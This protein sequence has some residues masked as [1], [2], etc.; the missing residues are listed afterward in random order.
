MIII[1]FFILL[2]V[3]IDIRCI[4][5]LKIE[6]YKGNF[7]FH[8][9]NK[10]KGRIISHLFVE[11]KY[12]KKLPFSDRFIIERL[13][14]NYKFISLNKGSK[15]IKD[16]LRFSI[17]NE[18]NNT[19]NKSQKERNTYKNK[20]SNNTNNR[21]NIEVNEKKKV[22]N[23]NYKNK[24]VKNE[25]YKNKKVE[26]ENY[27]NKNVENEN[28]KN[29]KVENENYKNKNVENE[30]YKN[31]NVENENYKNKNVENENYKNKNVENENYKNK[32]VKN[33]NYK[34]KNVENENY[35][36]KNVENENYKN[37]NVENENYK[38]KNVEK[39][40]S[41]KEAKSTKKE[42]EEIA[43]KKITKKI[44]KGTINNNYGYYN[45]VRS[46][47]N[48]VDIQNTTVRDF[49]IEHNE[50]RSLKLL[51]LIYKFW[52]NKNFLNFFD[53]L[54]N[55]NF[56]YTCIEKWLHK[57]S[58]SLSKKQLKIKIM[59]DHI[60]IKNE[61]FLKKKK[62]IKEFKISYCSINKCLN[63]LINNFDKFCSYEITSIVWAIT[64]I[65]IKSFK[66]SNN[67]DFGNSLEFN[68][69]NL[70][71]I[72]NFNTFFSLIIKNLNKIKNYLSVDEALWAIWSI[73]KLLYFNI[74]I[75]NYLTS[76]K[77][78][79]D[80]NLQNDNNNDNNS[81]LILD[82]SRGYI[83]NIE[84]NEN[85]NNLKK[86][87]DI[88]ILNSCTTENNKNLNGKKLNEIHD[89]KNFIKYNNNKIV[90]MMKKFKLTREIVINILDVFDYLYSKLYNNITFLKE[91][92]YIYIPFIIFESQTLILNNGIILLNRIIYLI[93]NNNILLKLFNFNS[94]K[95]TYSKNSNL[96]QNDL[97]KNKD[98]F[99][100]KTL[101]KVYKLIKCISK[102]FYPLKN[103]NLLNFDLHNNY[104][105]LNINILSKFINTCN[106]VL[107]KYIDYFIFIM[108][109]KN[110]TKEKESIKIQ[111]EKNQDNENNK[112]DN[113]GKE[114]NTEMNNNIKENII[115]LNDKVKL[116]YKNEIV[117]IYN[118]LK[119]SL[120]S[121]IK[122]DLKDKFIYEWLNK[123][124]HI[125]QFNRLDETNKLYELKNKLIENNEYPILNNKEENN[126]IN[127][128]MDKIKDNSIKIDENES[129]LMNEKKEIEEDIFSETNSIHLP[130]D[131]KSE[132]NKV[133]DEKNEKLSVL[134]N[135]DMKTYLN[136]IKNNSDINKNNSDV[137]LDVLA[138]SK[139]T[140][141]YNNEMKTKL[142]EN[143]TYS[144]EHSLKIFKI[145]YENEKISNPS[146]VTINDIYI[147]KDKNIEELYNEETKTFYKKNKSIEFRNII[148]PKQLSIFVNYI[149]RNIHLIPKQEL[150]NIFLISIKYAI[151]TKFNY[152]TSNDIIHFLQGLINYNE[153][154]NHSKFYYDVI[155]EMLMLLCDIVE[156]NFLNWKSSNI[157]Q[158]IYVLTKFKHIHK[159]IFNK[160]D[161]FLN[162]IKFPY[163]IYQKANYIN[164][165]NVLQ[166][167]HDSNLTE[168]KKNNNINISQISNNNS[169][170][171]NGN[172]NNIIE[173][174][175]KFHKNNENQR[176]DISINEFKYDNL[177]SAIWALSSLNKNVIK[178]KY[179]LK[180]FYFFSV[181]FSLH[182]K[183]Y[184][185]YKIR[186]NNYA[187][188]N[189]ENLKKKYLNDSKFLQYNTNYFKIPLDPMTISIYVNIFARK[190]KKGF[191][192]LFE[193]IYNN[194]DIINLF[195]LKELS[196]VIYSLSHINKNSLQD[197]VF[198][199]SIL[200]NINSLE[201]KESYF[202]EEF[203]KSNI[204]LWIEELDYLFCFDHSK[205]LHEIK[206]KNTDQS[207]NIK[208]EDMGNKNGENI[209]DN[210]YQTENDYKN[211][212]E[213]IINTNSYDEK[214]KNFIR[215]DKFLK[216]K[217]ERI[218]LSNEFLNMLMERLIYFTIYILEEKKNTQEISSNN[219]TFTRNFNKK[220]KIEIIDLI[221]L[222]YSF[223]ILL[224]QKVQINETKN[225]NFHR[226][227]KLISQYNLIV[228]NFLHSF[229][230]IYFV[231]DTYALVSNIYYLDQSTRNIIKEFVKICI[232][233]IEEEKI[234]DLEKKKITLSIQ[235][236]K[237]TNF[238]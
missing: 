112:I 145:I 158:L 232:K 221:K 5:S 38:N 121:L 180:F 36:N 212:S 10:N 183:L 25:N 68:N 224:N 52:K 98:I 190:I 115:E 186:N 210:I 27:K 18:S 193:V 73:C 56:D 188:Y 151:T 123:N 187:L 23:E 134:N 60:L 129:A 2:F 13:K 128:E 133:N 230:Y 125:F 114:N 34:N 171:M 209:N 195:S 234:L 202:L 70:T 126:S 130:Y 72:E 231:I 185:H 215:K 14:N 150:D 132:Y 177:G 91:K 41:Y 207:M 220:N 85:I 163:Y 162:N 35:K 175:N 196:H 9:Y 43:K 119:S 116:E 198:D 89:N 57:L 49:L 47:Y 118:C 181:Y 11:V 124:V 176:I 93:L 137:C 203:L 178:K 88:K 136:L 144:I 166:G 201:E 153:L 169:E 78:F 87:G 109:F 173:K 138:L 32:N 19:I 95:N 238:K 4:I 146:Y 223:F 217:H 76:S 122:L 206:N 237:V 219:R 139:F 157:C 24:N 74:S 225:I 117:F 39:K 222:I 194:V 46:T 3:L 143:V 97:D 28:Y 31:K 90:Y 192:F 160:F 235:N 191:Y 29:K 84:D 218:N 135:T 83:E 184:L 67:L 75:N 167:N 12:R 107:V 94:L 214:Y 172:F 15:N 228:K 42:N 147:I 79:I 131:S 40:V 164:H 33:E 226:L 127:L 59:N 16:K 20:T 152:F 211:D 216:L 61:H 101:S 233:K 80:K 100:I 179:Y 205:N 110:D 65:I 149:G 50:I 174:N 104:K 22:E 21:D 48:I 69:V 106:D 159:F 37:K 102:T 62:R 58:I 189:K 120:V 51:D 53:I 66:N 156:N 8:N 17:N 63:I 54:N 105:N 142:I 7:N 96:F 108:K 227:E 154:D 26:N 213:M 200:N 86:K 197:S 6:N 182:M 71:I 141:I 236:L 161:E 208:T 30:N 148:M 64:I 45:Q 155:N 55:E 92:Y 77:K 81:N 44:I 111:Y 82:I 229:N 199:I 1:Q 168:E 170:K 204:S 99:R 113:K 103:V 165:E 140:K